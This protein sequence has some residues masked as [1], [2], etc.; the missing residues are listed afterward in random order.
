MYN[1]KFTNDSIE[2]D[3]RIYPPGKMTN[4]INIYTEMIFNIK[5]DRNSSKY[6]RL[7]NNVITKITYA[8][9][10]LENTTLLSAGIVGILVI[11]AV[12]VANSMSFDINFNG[13]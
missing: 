11:L 1:Y 9:F 4:T 12:I 8:K 10:S 3:L 13:L 6:T 7:S 5:L 2:G